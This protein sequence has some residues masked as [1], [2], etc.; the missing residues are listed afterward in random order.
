MH[1]G[2]TPLMIQEPG[3]CM[4]TNTFKVEHLYLELPD[5]FYSR[6]TPTPLS[7]P[8]MVCF[9]HQLAAQLGFHVQNENDWAGIGAG[10]ELLEGLDPVAMKYTGHQ[11]RVDSRGVGDCRGLVLWETVAPDGI[12]RD[13]PLNGAGTPPSSP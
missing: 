4:S 6:V 9:N 11:I 13:W 8:K 12:R 1:R 5:S 7:E 2:L 3:Q 10:A